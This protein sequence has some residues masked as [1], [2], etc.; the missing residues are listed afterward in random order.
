MAAGKRPGR[1][2]RGVDG[3][4]SR[5]QILQVAV[6][7]LADGGYPGMSLQVVADRLGM[8]KSS[9][10]YHFDGKHQLASEAF[11]RI[12][13]EFAELLED[14]DSDEEPSLEQL[15]R[16]TD[17]CVD[18][19]VEH[20]ASVRL[21][22]RLFVDRSSMIRNVSPSEMDDPLV[23]VFEILG[24]WL[25]R[26]SSAGVIRK[27]DGRVA[28]LQVVGTLLFYPAAVQDVGESLFR[29]DPFSPKSVRAWKREL[30][31]FLEGAL[32]T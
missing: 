12:T 8:R 20:P 23:R 21:G 16:A 11:I 4:D 6:E 30:T 24:N 22:L 1:P 3:A 5:A 31:R 28:V 9:L 2:R 17:R 14:L 10:F 27:V 29:A 26:A 13:G 25:K 7:E 15:K 32:A 18:Y 19:A